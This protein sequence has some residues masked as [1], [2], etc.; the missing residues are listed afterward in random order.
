M[1]LFGG[2]LLKVVSY[3]VENPYPDLYIRELPIEVHT[4]FIERNKSIIRELLDIVIA[5][6]VYEEENDFEKRFNLKYVESIVRIRILDKEVASSCFNGVNDVSIPVSQFCDLQLPISNVFVVENQINFLTFPLVK[7]S[8]VIW[9]KGYAVSAIK[10]SAMLK[11][12]T[13]YYWGDFDAQGFEILSQFRGY[14]PQTESLLMDKL[15]FDKYF[16]NDKGTHSKVTIDLNLTKEEYSLY[17]Y[18]RTN[19]LRLEQE[20]IP[21]TY[22]INHILSQISK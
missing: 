4:K 5:P 22:V 14:F 18:I 16:E 9:G 3:F 1:L 12:S 2:D 17:N 19:K 21:Q 7:N 10:E 8:I 13:L 15:T 11:S 20:K 6:Y